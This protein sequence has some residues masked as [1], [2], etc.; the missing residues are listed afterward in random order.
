MGCSH[1]VSLGEVYWTHWFCIR[2]GVFSRWQIY[3]FRC[4]WQHT[5]IMG[6]SKVR[7]AKFSWIVRT[8]TLAPHIIILISF[9]HVVPKQLWQWAPQTCASNLFCSLHSKSQCVSTF[10]GHQDF[11]L[12]V[13]F[14]PYG[15]HIIKLWDTKNT[16]ALA[17][18]NGHKK[19]GKC[20][21]T[22][23]L[24]TNCKPSAKCTYRE[25][26]APSVHHFPA[27]LLLLHN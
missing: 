10:A 14:S 20:Q 11:V 17:T 15:T 25:R 24:H 4:S 5:Q 21:L 23:V 2:C 19:T 12:S 18:I 27:S 22:N 7:K 8:V 3:C 26:A 13:A 6:S 16:T 9:V 1:W